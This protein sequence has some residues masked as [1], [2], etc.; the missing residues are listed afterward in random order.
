MSTAWGTLDMR[1]ILETGCDSVYMEIV[2]F[3]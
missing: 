1:D 2:V 3:P